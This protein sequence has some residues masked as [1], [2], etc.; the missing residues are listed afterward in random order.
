MFDKPANCNTYSFAAHDIP[1]PEARNSFF[2]QT[3]DRI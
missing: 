3:C 2:N 1:S